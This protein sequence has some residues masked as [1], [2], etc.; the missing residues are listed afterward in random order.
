MNTEHVVENVV[1]YTIND[2]RD[3]ETGPFR[4]FTTTLDPTYETATALAAT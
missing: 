3:V 1:D 2:G 4:R